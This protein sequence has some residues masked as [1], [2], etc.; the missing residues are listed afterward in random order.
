MGCLRQDRGSVLRPD[1]AVNC[2]SSETQFCR[3]LVNINSVFLPSETGR[4]LS[5]ARSKEGSPDSLIKISPMRRSSACFRSRLLAQRGS[6]LLL[7]CQH[8]QRVSSLRNRK[9]LEKIPYQR[10]FARQFLYDRSGRRS[11]ACF[12]SRLLAQR[13]PALLPSVTNDITYSRA[14]ERE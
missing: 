4:K 2:S 10:G 6:I 13:E 8:Q 1:F 9:K 11:S 5:K 14:V 3:H 7:P 12:H